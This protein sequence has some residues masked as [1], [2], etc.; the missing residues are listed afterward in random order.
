MMDICG[1]NVMVVV[2]MVLVVCSCVVWVRFC[3]RPILPFFHSH[4]VLIAVH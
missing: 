2:T 4:P 3:I 1:G